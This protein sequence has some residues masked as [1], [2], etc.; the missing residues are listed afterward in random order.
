[1]TDGPY[2]QTADDLRRAPEGF[3]QCRS[4]LWGIL[5]AMERVGPAQCS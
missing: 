5:D 4:L 3:S 2:V 1:L